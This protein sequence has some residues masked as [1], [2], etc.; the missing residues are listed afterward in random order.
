MKNR[1]PRILTLL[2]LGTGG[3]IGITIAHTLY[4]DVSGSAWR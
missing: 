1:Q 3:A 4:L 2:S